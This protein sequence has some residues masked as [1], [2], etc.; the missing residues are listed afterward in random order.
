MTDRMYILTA[1]ARELYGKIVEEFGMSLIE[2]T[3]R[4][5]ELN[6]TEDDKITD[7]ML[8]EAR[9]D[10]VS[11]E[12]GRGKNRYVKRRA[13]SVV[14][15]VL[16]MVYMLLGSLMCVPLLKT[17]YQ[18]NNMGV[19]ILIAGMLV[20]LG[21]FAYYSRNTWLYYLSRK[22]GKDIVSEW[23]EIERLSKRLM[24]RR[25]MNERNVRFTSS[26]LN[27]LAKEFEGHYTGKEIRRILEARNEVLYNGCGRLTIKAMRDIC[28]TAS[29]I[30]KDLEETLKKTPKGGMDK[31]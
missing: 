20:V 16:G 28:R 15:M 31:R 24:L 7:E 11:V 9:K 12:A 4:I 8:L 30:V 18:H 22:L 3:K 29:N 25:G 27:F 5:A 6:G 13:L 19:I 10:I 1:S 17:E 21:S 14:M 2:R 26:R 23:S